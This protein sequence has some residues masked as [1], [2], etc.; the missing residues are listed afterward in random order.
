MRFG[1]I[2][3]C[4]E[5]AGGLIVA[6]RLGGM[7]EV[8]DDCNWQH[9]RDAVAIAQSVIIER[10]QEWQGVGARQTTAGTAVHMARTASIKIAPFL[11]IGIL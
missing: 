10:Q 1:E 5:P 6:A 8:F 11:P 2:N 9:E 4:D 7:P 3:V